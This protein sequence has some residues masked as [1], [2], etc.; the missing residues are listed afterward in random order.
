MVDAAGELRSPDPPQEAPPDTALQPPDEADHAADGEGLGE[1]TP[2]TQ[3][4]EK[5]QTT[6]QHESWPELLSSH[7]LKTLV[8]P[9]PTK[10]PPNHGPSRCSIERNPYQAPA[11]PSSDSSGVST[12][13]SVAK[14]READVGGGK[15]KP[16][17][18]QVAP[19]AKQHGIRRRPT[20]IQT[21]M[22][23]AKDR[24]INSAPFEFL[25]T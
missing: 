23:S 15:R 24:H 12:T 11:S 8:V 13:T 3:L 6:P 2:S 25:N 7:V 5:M 19:F 18:I 22:S 10:H 21:T 1:V 4:I 20:R 16:S 14:T 17:A 9:T